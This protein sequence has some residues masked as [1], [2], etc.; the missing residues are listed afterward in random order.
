MLKLALA[1]D[2][3]LISKANSKLVLLGPMG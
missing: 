1:I 3:D 2:V